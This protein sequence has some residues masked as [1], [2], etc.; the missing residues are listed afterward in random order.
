MLEWIIV[1]G[2]V[3]G[4][5]V[6]TYLIKSGA[7]QVEDILI[8]DP[9]EALLYNWKCNTDRIGMEYLRSPGVH[10]IDVK[11][12]SL[13]QFGKQLGDEKGFYGHYKRPSLDLFNDHCKKILK[14]TKMEQSFYQGEVVSVKRHGQGWNVQTDKGTT[15]SG[16][17]I[18]VAISTSGQPNIPEWAQDL[19]RASSNHLQHIYQKSNLDLTNLNPPIVVVGGGISAAHTVIK[20]CNLYPGKVTLLKRHPFRIH[21]FDSDPGWLG[22][23]HMRTFKMIP[24]YDERRRV[25]QHA[26]Y[27]GSIPKEL[28][29]KIR[30]LVKEGKLSIVDGEVNTVSKINKNHNFLIHLDQQEKSI[31]ANS[32]I[33][34][35]GFQSSLPNQG[36]LKKLIVEE[37]LSCAS[38]GYPIV[39]ESL[40]WCSHL[41]VAGPLAELAIGPVSR[42]I[43]GARRAAESIVGNYIN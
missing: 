22:P 33:L 15:F 14:E 42:N 2:G 40:E 35:T 19:K 9:N 17:R 36:W 27:R 23:K 37:K 30:S 39:N 7:S 29:L 41:Y 5:T 21:D 13:E 1:G 25:I 24:D 31:K 34:A 11:P 38:C 10:H 4:C 6:A 16:K 43:S 26:R 12:F 28:H 8:I 32:V 3:H 18:V 20:L